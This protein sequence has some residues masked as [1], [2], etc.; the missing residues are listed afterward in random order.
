M[1]KRVTLT[2]NPKPHLLKERSL[3][4]QLLHLPR[5]LW[6]YKR[7]H[8]TSSMDPGHHPLRPSICRVRALRRLS[9]RSLARFP[10]TRH[11]RDSVAHQSLRPRVSC[12][13]PFF[14][15][16]IHRDTIC[17]GWG[18]FEGGLADPACV[19]RL[20]CDWECST[21]TACNFRDFCWVSRWS[22]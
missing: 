11:S 22:C 9:W 13:K 12:R 6:D 18:C 10:C 14:Q 16:C 8:R 5:P 15:R 3:S 2:S 4:P 1:S 7:P 20:Y 17:P 19:H 21:C